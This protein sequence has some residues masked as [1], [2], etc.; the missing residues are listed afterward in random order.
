[1]TVRT[2]DERMSAEQF[3]GSGPCV[4]SC[5]VRHT[6]NRLCSIRRAATSHQSFTHIDPVVPHCRRVLDYEGMAVTV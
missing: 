5:L 4:F 2:N 3:L 6:L 1:M